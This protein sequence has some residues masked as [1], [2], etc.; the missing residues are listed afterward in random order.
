MVWV[1]CSNIGDA[2]VLTDLLNQFPSYQDIDSMTADE[3][4]DTCKYHETIA[5][6][7]VHAVIPLRKN[8]KCWK[9][10]GEGAIPPKRNETKRNDAVSAQRYVGRT[11]WRCWSGYH[12]R[13]R[14]KTKMHCLRLMSQS[15][16]VREFERQI[17][18]IQIYIAFCSRYTA[19]SVFITVP[20]RL[21]PFRVEEKTSS[22]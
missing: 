8:A 15:P 7:N 9:P 22:T 5:A 18:E 14:V 2:P 11:L 1:L 13:S 4:Y 10:T 21:S 6:R 3:A 20:C 12:R 16:V 17:A 19:L